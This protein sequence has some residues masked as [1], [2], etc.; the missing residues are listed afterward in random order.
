[1]TLEISDWCYKT[2]RTHFLALKCTQSGLC[3][4][5]PWKIFLWW[6]V[7]IIHKQI[8]ILSTVQINQVAKKLRERV[9]ERPGNEATQML[10]HHVSFAPSS[11]SA[12][13]NRVWL[14]SKFCGKHNLRAGCCT[15][16]QQGSL[17]SLRFGPYPDLIALALPH[18]L[19]FTLKSAWT[20]N[21]LAWQC[22][23]VIYRGLKH[24]NDYLG[25]LPK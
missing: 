16:S 21:F 4:I 12:P 14:L 13:M 15:L 24:C 3:S 7:I 5:F 18:R 8:N 10:Q 25:F 11:H 22:K 17:F 23:K 1:M 20:P 9:W 2:L 19:S 6:V